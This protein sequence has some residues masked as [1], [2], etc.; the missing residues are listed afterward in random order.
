MRNHVGL[1][2]AAMLAA[3]MSC[4]AQLKAV[5]GDWPAWRGPDRTGV[6]PESGLLVSWPAGGPKLA[7]Q[8]TEIGRG[9]STPSIVAGTLYLLGTGEGETECLLAVSAKD[10]AV[11]WRTPFGKTRGGYPGP[12]STPTFDEGLLYV[13]SSDG[14]LLCA[15]ARTGAKKWMKDLV[16]D[17]GGKCGGWAYA[18]SPLIDG[19]KVVCTPGGEVSTMVALDK[20][21]G[22]KLWTCSVT[23]E[24]ASAE[25]PSGGGG[26]RRP[27]KPYAIAG[28]ASIVAAEIGGVRQYVQF[29]DGGVIG[30]SAADG[31]LLWTYDA[32]A[33]STA[34]CTTPI[35]SGDIVFAASAYNTGGGAARISRTPSGFEAKEI[36]FLKDFQNHHGGVVLIGGHLYGTGASQ[37][38]CVD[39][40][41]GAVAW[42]APSV[43]KGSVVA[44][45]GQL[46]VRSE[47][48]PIALVDASPAAY[49]E[50]GRFDQ[51]DRRKEKAWPHILVAGGRMVVRDQDLLL[52]YDVKK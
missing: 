2:A 4:P 27:S 33:S 40:K 43:G 44:A 34:N 45:G 46:Y 26:R 30:V 24:R 39:L 28:Y 7:W 16:A 52:C 15:D 20:K 38:L 36:W 6:S 31:K 41:T 50:K 12:R 49:S 5:P 10:G 42:R 14:K 25:A 22:A 8:T 19:P 37:L 23:K 32:P 13:I 3:S 18:E 29:L 17:F 1:T 47:N 35:V 9:Y 48:G 51:P 21:T 11:L